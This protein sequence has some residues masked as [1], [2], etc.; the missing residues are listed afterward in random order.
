MK[1]KIYIANITVRATTKV[2]GK[3]TE[4][5]DYKL[6][7]HPL[8]MINEEVICQSQNRIF[9]YVYKK[10]IHKKTFSDYSFKIIAVDDKKFSSEINY[11]LQT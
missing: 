7:L 8:T 5:L 2:R 10:Y 3:R 6:M 9:N 11:I 1:P 4:S